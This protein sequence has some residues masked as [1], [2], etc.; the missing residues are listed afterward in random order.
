MKTNRFNMKFR[1]IVPRTLQ[2]I[3]SHLYR[4]CHFQAWFYLAFKIVIVEKTAKFK[5]SL[6]FFITY[7][8]YLLFLKYIINFKIFN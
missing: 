3:F 1:F 5:I 7:N 6:I 8:F 2:P 4:F